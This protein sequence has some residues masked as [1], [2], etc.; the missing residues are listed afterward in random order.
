MKGGGSLI[1]YYFQIDSDGKGESDRCMMDDLLEKLRTGEV[2]VRTTRRR[3]KKQRT[4]HTEE[5]GLSAAD[6]LKSLEAD[7]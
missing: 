1:T 7:E 5:E 6:L 3:S 2:E 4:E